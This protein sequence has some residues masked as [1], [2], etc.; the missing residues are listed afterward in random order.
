MNIQVEHNGSDISN[1]VINY[2]REH[3][4]CTGIGVLTIVISDDIATTFNPWDEIDIF[5][6]GEF[7]VRYYVSSVEWSVPNSTITLN[8]QDESKR[9][10]DYFI[11]DQYT[12]ETPTYTRFW[13]EK[14]LDEVGTS[15]Q[16][17]T[18]SQGNLLSNYTSMGMMSA[19]EQ[20]II[21]LQLSG[22]YMYFDG[23][24]VA[25][26][27]TLNTELSDYAG[28]MQKTDI[29]DI[30]VKKDDRMLRNR[31]VV[32]GNYNPISLT[33][34]FADVTIHTPWNYDH[35]DVRTMVIANSNIPN[36]SSAYNIANL[37]VKEFARI[38]VEKHLTVHGAR[39]LNLGDVV[40]VYSNVYTGSGLVT[41]FGVTMGKEGLVTNL[42]LDERCPRLFGYFNFGDYVYVGT[43]GDGVW[44]KHLKFIH[45]WE[46]F[47]SGLDDLRVTDL[48]IN[49]GI[50]SSVTASGGMFYKVFDD[51]P[52]SQIQHPE[53]LESSELDTLGEGGSGLVLIPFSGVKARATMVD[54]NLNRI[55]YGLDTYSGENL[56]DYYLE[57][58][59]MMSSSGLFASGFVVN[60][61]LTIDSR[62]WVLAYTP[63]AGSYET[64][65]ISVSG[66]YDIKV[67]DIENDGKNDYVSVALGGEGSLPIAFA[68]F[69]YVATQPFAATLDTN[70]TVVMPSSVDNINDNE[71]SAT[72]I[73]MPT[74]N[75]NSLV[76]MD[77][78]VSNMRMVMSI[79]K[80]GELK[81]TKFTRD[82]NEETGLYEINASSVTNTSGPTFAS[83]NTIIGIYPNFGEDN[84]IIYYHRSSALNV[85]TFY[86]IEW[87]VPTDTVES[88]VSMGVVDYSDGPDFNSR[89]ALAVNGTIYVLG[90]RVDNPATLGGSHVSPSFIRVNVTRIGMQ[91]K[92]FFNDEIFEL[93]TGLFGGTDYYFFDNVGLGATSNTIFGIFQ[94]NNDVKIIGW[95]QLEAHDDLGND[96]YKEYVFAGNS[97]TVQFNEVYDSD[98]DHRI[99]PNG[100]VY[101]QINETKGMIGWRSSGGNTGFIFDGT[102]FKTFTDAPYQYVQQS[103]TDSLDTVYPI[104][105][106]QQY[107]IAKDTSDGS[108]NLI[109][110]ANYEPIS[111]IV[112]PDDYSIDK[113]YSSV[114]TGF[115]DKIY[116]QLAGPSGRC[117]VPYNFSSF[118]LTKELHPVGFGSTFT[119]RVTHLGGMFLRESQ[120]YTISDP[121]AAIFYIDMGDTPNRGR[122]LVLQRDGVDFNIVQEAAYPI[123]VDISNF[124][125]L[126]TL[127]NKEATF[128]SFSI[129]DREVFQSTISPT[130]SGLLV[131]VPDYR[132]AMLPGSGELGISNQAVYIRETS[133]WE[134][135][136]LT[137]SGIHLQYEDI[138]GSG[139]L[140]RIETSNFVA[141]GQYIFVTT[142]GDFP[143]FYQKDPEL[144]YFTLYSGL[145]DS[146]ATII[147]L[148]D[149]I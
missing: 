144:E 89:T 107:Y 111:E 74:A 30:N 148:D 43:Y 15:Y 88:E 142:S 115:G 65:P 64:Y 68:N 16:F 27:G 33:R 51:V 116:F 61:G 58:S 82:F 129:Y 10:I 130:F 73:S 18:S 83:G 72:G 139:L 28:S 81:R 76:A 79:G 35:N 138:A 55:I 78:P 17:Q 143:Q 71:N 77:N 48:H 49:N 106:N 40:K 70:S 92:T 22:W 66:E 23:N 102:V 104:F 52:W 14:F 67:I 121:L 84:Y 12:V 3:K 147:R 8:C 118:D 131:D 62:G 96:S 59:G 135:D 119:R 99:S 25:Q 60:S 39:D 36:N 93:E 11:S 126:L 20:I 9:L 141:S 69:G 2:E 112:P 101:T 133:V 136:A 13:I 34:I 109:S 123:R 132:Y 110:A 114:S 53:S 7:K 37:L 38:T 56:G 128:N 32:W 117:L 108:W 47:S 1:K 120:D 85:Y 46:D 86:Y 42:I 146:R 54:K 137:F 4:I 19:Y 140:N 105:G 31:A 26:I 90:Q 41:T 149:R 75:K 94:N 80:D 113:P 134:F 95:T 29:L 103:L 24:G 5:E 122:F 45:T 97:T 124:S 87:D 127:Q 50:F 125:P 6:E 91:F 98:V 145:P 57:L 100:L 63:G 21:L 44:R